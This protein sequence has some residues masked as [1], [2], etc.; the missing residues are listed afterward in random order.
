M[1]LEDKIVL[2]HKGCFNKECEKMYRE[3]SKEV[4]ALSVRKDYIHI[5]E[6]DVRKSKDGILYCYHGTLIQYWLYLVIPRIFSDIKKRYHIDTLEEIL[7]VIPED[8]IIVLDLKSKSITKA[9]ILNALKGKKYKKVILGNTSLSSVSFLERFND[10]PEEFVKVMNGNIFCKFY[11][12]AKLKD[13]NYKYFEVVFPFQVSKKII[14][15]VSR[16]GMEFRCA[17]LFFSSKESYWNKINKCN[18]KHVS[19][20]F[21]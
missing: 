2:T 13:K 17:G 1:N 6:I 4:C 19:S 3:N 21:I 5:I 12:L 8:K 14:D 20:D 11:D 7:G 16:C 15:D 9:D 18:I 10:M